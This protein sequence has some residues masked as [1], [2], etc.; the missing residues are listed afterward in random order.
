MA[1]DG[2][3]PQRR[4][5]PKP[6][7]IGIAAAL[8]LVV[9]IGGFAFAQTAPITVSVNGVEHELGG[10]K[11]IE[12][13]LDEG[14]A[15]PQPGD[16]V[17]V[18]GETLTAGEGDRLFATV[19]GQ[20]TRDYAAR[21]ASNDQVTIE[22]G[23]DT[24]EPFKE[25]TVEVDFAVREEG[26]GTITVQQSEG[27]KGVIATRVGDISGKTAEV[28][29]QVK[30]DQVFYK[31]NPKV[32]TDKVI[33]L[34]FDDGPWGDQTQQILDILAENDAKATFFVVGERVV[35]DGIDL[36]KKAKEAGHQVATHTYSHASGSGGGVDMGKMKP[37]EQIAEV[38]KGYEAIKNA[39]GEEPS[40]IFRSPGGNYSLETMK[41]LVP[42]VQA[43]IRW[44]ID[45]E[46]WRKPGPEVIADHILSAKPG[47][48][49]L[50][51]DGGGKRG[52]TI[53]GLKAALPQLKEQGYRFITIDELLE[54]PAS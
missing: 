48:I 27:V 44:N 20:E 22:N 14:F 18:A 10:D 33:A 35:G 16:L 1:Y 39:T 36:V 42:Y 30:Q 2:R 21:L 54:Y 23:H 13:I 49:V 32:G 47:S 17:D 40:H 26:V 7:L 52:E 8:V 29:T 38:T 15:S 12:A 19:N 11:N 53:E 24:I 4:Q 25:S 5:L 34:T 31:Y 9:G 37:E 6:L 51:H 3:A 43:E 50:A 45:T 41:I 28:E 46:D